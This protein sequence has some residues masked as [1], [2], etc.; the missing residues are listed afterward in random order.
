MR[1][2]IAGMFNYYPDW[3]KYLYRI[4]GGFVRLL[5]VLQKS[6]VAQLKIL[7]G[8]VKTLASVC[9][10]QLFSRLTFCFSSYLS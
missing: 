10:C 6:W 8:I 9:L 7:C 2:F 4:R 5:S 3:M 1:E